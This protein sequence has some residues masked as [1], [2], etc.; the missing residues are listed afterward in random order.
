[1]GKNL[2]IEK[3]SNEEGRYGEVI[4]KLFYDNYIEL[5]GTNEKYANIHLND[6]TKDANYQKIDC[7]FHDKE[8]N[9]LV[10]VKH[11]TWI[12]GKKDNYPKGTGNMPYE[13]ATHVPDHVIS[14]I[15]EQLPSDDFLDNVLSTFPDLRKKYLGC[16][17]KCEADHLFLV[18]GEEE[19][20]E[21][22]KYRLKKIWIVE[23]KKL[24]TYVHNVLVH[25]TIARGDEWFRFT[26]QPED[27]AYNAMVI[28]PIEKLIKKKFII[29][30]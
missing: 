12:A 13:F 7:D 9:I 18:G 8:R 5:G 19:S 6:T 20:S 27:K 30:F 29:T 22:R 3:T 25:S 1:M 26:Y 16:N 10:E 11:D 14:S 23:N 17:E 24:K 28:I 15:K 2:I 21:N 4:A